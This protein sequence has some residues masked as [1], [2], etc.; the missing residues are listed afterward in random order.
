MAKIPNSG[1]VDMASSCT[2]ES[3][4]KRVVSVNDFFEGSGDLISIGDMAEIF[5]VSPRTLRLYHDM[6]QLVPQYV[7]DNNGYRY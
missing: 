2:P 7:N 5:N 1:L 4:R 3:K 6:G